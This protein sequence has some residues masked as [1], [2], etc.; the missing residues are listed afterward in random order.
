MNNILI[1]GGGEIGQ[2]LAFMLKDNESVIVYDQDSTRSQTTENLET[3]LPKTKIVFLAV[4]TLALSSLALDLKSNLPEEAMIVLLSKGLDDKSR[5]APEILEE[6]GITQTLVMMAGPM[7]AEELL[8]NKQGF[9]VVASD[10]IETAED[11]INLFSTCPN[12]QLDASTDLIGVASLG[13]LKNIYTILLSM[14]NTLDL[15]SN[16]LGYLFKTSLLEMDEITKFLGGRTDIISLPGVADLIA[17]AFSPH[18]ANQAVGRDLVLK[19]VA[20]YSEGHESLPYLISRLGDKVSELPLLEIVRTV[21]INK[22]KAQD[23]FVQYFQK[24]N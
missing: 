9:A 22:V 19:G 2:A 23:V 12:L 3:L 5:L 7:L 17:T 4:P 11:V 15:G 20:S 6:E 1:I 10:K 21:I 24:Q 13:V 14:A 16:T 18:S 8:A